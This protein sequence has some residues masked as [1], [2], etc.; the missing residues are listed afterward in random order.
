MTHID[1]DK[2]EAAKDFQSIFVHFKC[3]N[4]KRQAIRLHSALS[5][6]EQIKRLEPVVAQLLGEIEEMDL[7][8]SRH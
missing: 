1:P 2:I 5:I 6:E 8:D 7:K 4:G 3:K